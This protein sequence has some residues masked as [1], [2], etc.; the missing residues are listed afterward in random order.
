[1][2]DIDFINM[3]AIERGAPAGWRWFAQEGMHGGRLVTGAV[4]HA[5]YKSG[6]RQGQTNWAKRDKTTERKILISDEALR[7][8]C[9]KWERDTGKCS[10]C[11]GTGAAWAGWSRDKGDFTKPCRR[12]GS[13][14]KAPT[15]DG[16]DVVEVLQ[17]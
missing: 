5:L 10:E 4:C 6:P 1:M 8:R 12:C 9:A 17:R 15:I 16:S 2:S 13:T 14:G 11:F 3:I 7:D